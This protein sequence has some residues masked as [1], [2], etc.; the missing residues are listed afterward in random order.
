MFGTEL[1][2]DLRWPVASRYVLRPAVGDYIS[3]GELAIF[4]A[5]NSVVDWRRPLEDTPGL[6][7]EFAALDGSEKSCLDFAHKHGVLIVSEYT[8]EN[9]DAFNIE[10]VGKWREGIKYIKEVIA[11]CEYCS[12][13]PAEAFR[14]FKNKEL[15]L[16]GPGEFSLSMKSSRSPLSLD[17]RFNSLLAAMEFE[18][19]KSII[20]GRKSTQCIECSKWFEV[21]SGGRR[22]QAKFCSPRCKD[23]YHNRLKASKRDKEK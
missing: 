16:H 13:K 21:G 7:A 14:Q 15:S 22:S 11:F 9:M 3:K 19:A 6:Y 4:P 1:G 10:T 17:V 8:P 5:E 18:A 12:S 2:I 23:S 20:S